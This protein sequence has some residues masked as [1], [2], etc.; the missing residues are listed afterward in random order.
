MVVVSRLT[1][2][3][4]A[5]VDRSSQPDTAL[6][7][8]LDD[9][10]VSTEARAAADGMLRDCNADGNRGDAEIDDGSRPKTLEVGNKSVGI[11]ALP[12]S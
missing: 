11:A 3:E 9:D 7:V 2:C 5:A 6:P 1:S 8:E 12:P 10:A 4:W